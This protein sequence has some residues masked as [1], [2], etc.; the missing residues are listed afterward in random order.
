M[1]NASVFSRH[2]LLCILQDLGNPRFWPF[3]HEVEYDIAD[4]DHLHGLD[5]YEQWCEDLATIAGPWIRLPSRHR[6]PAH[7]TK[8][9]C[10]SMHTPDVDALVIAMVYR[11][12]RR[13]MQH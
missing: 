6:A 9:G 5:V 1:I 2:D 4:G 8:S 11:Q 10:S 3:L 7:F 13:P 12:D